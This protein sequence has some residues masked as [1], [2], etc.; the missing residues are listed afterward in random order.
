MAY[1]SKNAYQKWYDQNKEHI[2]KY[3]REQMRKYR[4]ANPEKYRAQSRKAK[5]KLKD[6][7]FDLYG[8]ACSICGYN[9]IR[10]LTLDHIKNNG[11]EE[12]KRIGERG[13]YRRALEHHPDEYRTLCMNC[14]FIKRIEAQRQNQHG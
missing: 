11:A 2:R 9:D 5:A 8:R 6:A 14:Q 7:V 1:S 10:A 4:A 13:I 12:R 3:K